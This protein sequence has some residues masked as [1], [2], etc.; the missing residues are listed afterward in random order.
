MYLAA[1]QIN[2]YSRTVTDFTIFWKQNIPLY[3]KKNYKLSIFIYLLIIYF[4]Y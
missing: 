1:S 2:L 3:F 4:Y